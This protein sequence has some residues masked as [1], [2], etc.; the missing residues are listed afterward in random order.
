MYAPRKAEPSELLRRFAVELA[1]QGEPAAD[2]AQLLGVGERSVW[3]WLGVWR[4]WGE[5]SLATGRRSGRPPKLTPR[6]GRALLSWLDRSPRDF[7]FATERWTA[8][9]LASVLRRESGVAVNHRYL[10]DW[11]GRHGVTPQVPQRVP[12]ERDE[13]KVAAWAA[14][15]W[16]LIK[17][18]WPSGPP[19]SALPTKAAS[20]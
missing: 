2:V 20:C 4:A 1:E 8:P 12:R 5:G 15:Q 16:P 18:R 11:L 13:A 3:R 14:E 19:L 9:R 10:N 7:G 6:R 17:K